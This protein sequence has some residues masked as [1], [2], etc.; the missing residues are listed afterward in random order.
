MEIWK[1]LAIDTD[2]KFKSKADNQ[3]VSGVKFL[4][5]P[6]ENTCTERTRYRGFEWIE[7]FISHERL[8]ALVKKSGVKPMPGDVIQ[9][10]FNRH[11][12]IEDIVVVDAA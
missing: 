6:T 9:L 8:D 3:N 5:T 11:G 12:T 2:Y 10:T 4:L 1:L 7:Q